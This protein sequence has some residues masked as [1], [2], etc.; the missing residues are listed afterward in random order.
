M[1]A[2]VAEKVM[3]WSERVEV[4]KARSLKSAKYWRIAFKKRRG[5]ED[6]YSIGDYSC[7][8]D[9]DGKKVYCGEPHEIHFPPSYSERMGDAWEVVEILR[10]KGVYLDVMSAS[11][12]FDVHHEPLLSRSAKT[13]PHAICLAALSTV[14]ID[15]S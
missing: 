4:S 9:R 8:V 11:K 12:G 2:L 14:G 7:F 15:I 3:G 5:D 10:R 6:D 1:D 13:A